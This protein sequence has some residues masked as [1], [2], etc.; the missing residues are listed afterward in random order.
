LARRLGTLPVSTVLSNQGAQDCFH[1]ERITSNNYSKWTRHAAAAQC[2]Y[3]KARVIAPTAMLLM[4][5]TG[6]GFLVWVRRV[7]NRALAKDDDN[8]TLGR[9][10]MGCYVRIPHGRESTCHEVQSKC[11]D[12]DRAKLVSAEP[13]NSQSTR[14]AGS[15]FPQTVD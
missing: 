6:P 4:E 8:C 2:R 1:Q 10:A 3:S 15:E 11:G 14:D 9:W 13:D 5:F 7:R 12:L